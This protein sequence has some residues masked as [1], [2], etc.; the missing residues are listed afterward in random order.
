MIPDLAPYQSE[1]LS[2]YVIAL[3]ILVFAVVATLLESK[4]ARRQLEE[5]ERRGDGNED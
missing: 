2:A 1:V 3:V 5:L 4:R